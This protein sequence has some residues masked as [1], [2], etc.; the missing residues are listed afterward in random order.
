MAT[1]TCPLCER[2]ACLFHFGTGCAIVSLLISVSPNGGLMHGGHER[3]HVCTECVRT[4]ERGGA[5]SVGDV[6]AM[7]RAR[8]AAIRLSEDK[9]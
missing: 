7:L 6:G 3:M 8:C 9:K 4:L 2:D 1:A 5:Q